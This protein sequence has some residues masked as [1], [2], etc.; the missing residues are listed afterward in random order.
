LVLALRFNN[1]FLDFMLPPTFE[2]TLLTLSETT[3]LTLSDKS[4]EGVLNLLIDSEV[5]FAILLASF[6]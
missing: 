6:F 1:L 5:L 4:K 3:L 2:V